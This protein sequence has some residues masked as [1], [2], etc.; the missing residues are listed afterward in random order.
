MVSD[1]QKQALAE[2]EASFRSHAVTHVAEDN[3]NVI[4]W[5]ADLDIGAQYK[6]AVSTI[7]FVLS[8]HYPAAD[9]YPHYLVGNPVRVSGAELGA[10][11]TRPRWRD[12]EV[13]QV[14]RKSNRWNPAV[15]TA[16]IKLAK[17][18]EWV[19]GQAA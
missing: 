7:A 6:P 15:D 9:V 19:R 1:A 10:G 17:V 13:V 2:L 8:V 16:A 11:M 4:V 12:A 18:L 5:V 14:S 3:G